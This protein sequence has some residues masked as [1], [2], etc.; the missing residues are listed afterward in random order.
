MGSFIK[1]LA[2]ISLVIISSIE[3]ADGRFQYVVPE[4]PEGFR[5]LDD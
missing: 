4:K 2:F 3:V 5:A 1:K